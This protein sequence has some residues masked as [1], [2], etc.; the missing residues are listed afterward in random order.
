MGESQA[1]SATFLYYQYSFSATGP[2][3]AIQALLRAPFAPR[4]FP[5]A[6][7]GSSPA[8]PMASTR[9]QTILDLAGSVSCLPGALP[10]GPFDVCASFGRDRG[11]PRDPRAG[12][13]AGRRRG[14]GRVAQGARQRAAGPRARSRPPAGCRLP[15][16]RTPRTAVIRCRSAPRGRQRRPQAARRGSRCPPRGPQRRLAAGQHPPLGDPQRPRI[17]LDLPSSPARRWLQHPTAPPAARSA[18]RSAPLSGRPTMAATRQQRPER[19]SLA[20]VGVV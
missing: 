11:R 3:S 1:I 20:A 13:G 12:C 17:G 18:A 10:A 7:G 9:S 16:D 15:P 5:L 6:R 4:R 2:L 19:P 8:A 14:Q